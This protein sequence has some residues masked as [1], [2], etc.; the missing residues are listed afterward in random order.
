MATGD[1]DKGVWERR[2]HINIIRAS[3]FAHKPKLSP[4]HHPQNSLWFVVTPIK[5][6][7]PSLSGQAADLR[8][9][10]QQIGLGE[11]LQPDKGGF[12]PLLFYLKSIT[13]AFT[14]SNP[15]P[16]LFSLSVVTVGLGQLPTVSRC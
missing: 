14:F 2:G 12:L 16:L 10:R 5:P 8:T 7:K 6:A 11:G 3:S 13:L 4:H 1:K 9:P 15:L